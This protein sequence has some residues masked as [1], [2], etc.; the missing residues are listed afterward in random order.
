MRS[1]LKFTGARPVRFERE[2][3]WI[4]CEPH[5]AQRW[6]PVLADRV[7]MPAPY[8]RN[9]S[10][11]LDMI[12]ANIARHSPLPRDYK[13]GKQMGKKTDLSGLA[14]AVEKAKEFGLDRIANRFK[15][16]SFR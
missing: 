1:S 13:L 5:K 11:A 4:E 6:Q 14:S 15:R 3:G 2:S 16:G 8:A 12:S 9:K 7:L 10:H